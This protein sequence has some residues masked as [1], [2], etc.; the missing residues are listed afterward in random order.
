MQRLGKEEGGMEKSCI[1]ARKQ[2]GASYPSPNTV[3]WGKAWELLLGTEA[4]KRK[5]AAQKVIIHALIS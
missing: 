4:G 2:S 5:T 3:T 1:A